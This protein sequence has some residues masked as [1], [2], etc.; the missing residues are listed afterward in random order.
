MESGGTWHAG[1]E[2][3]TPLDAR[4]ARARTWSELRSALIPLAERAGTNVPSADVSVQD[5][6]TFASCLSIEDDSALAV[7]KRAEDFIEGHREAGSEHPGGD[8]E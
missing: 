7:L 5:F 1:I 4:Y 8:C 3:P 6:R 2:A